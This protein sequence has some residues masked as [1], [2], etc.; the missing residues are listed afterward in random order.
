MH[1]TFFAEKN[2]K[3]LILFRYSGNYAYFCHDDLDIIQ[4]QL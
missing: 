3:T 4:K 2:K 1:S